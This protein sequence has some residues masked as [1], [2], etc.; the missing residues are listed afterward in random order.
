M[1][2]VS[3][4]ANSAR[5]ALQELSLE[6]QVQVACINSAENVTLSGQSDAISNLERHFSSKQ[7][8]ARKLN[9]N[10]Q[11]YHTSQMAHAEQYYRELLEGI[12][13]SFKGDAKPTDSCVSMV[14][15]LT[16]QPAVPSDISSPTYWCANLQSP[17]L[18]EHATRTLLQNH[19]CH[20]VEIGPYPALKNYILDIR[21]HIGLHETQ[22]AYF[23]SLMRDTNSTISLLNLVG[24][25]Y[26]TGEDLP[27]D[28][29]N[30]NA[31]K[32]W[33]DLPPYPWT[34]EDIPCFEP[35]ISREFRNRQYPRHELLGSR[36]VGCHADTAFWR[37]TIRLDNIPWLQDHVI[38]GTCVFPGAAYIAIAVEGLSQLC[39]LE[40]HWQS[41][42]YSTVILQEV[43]IINALRF[44]DKEQAVEMVT[45]LQPKHGLD[46]IDQNSRPKI[47]WNFTISSFANGITTIHS[48]GQIKLGT[49]TVAGCCGLP[50]ADLS[51]EDQ[52]PALWYRKLASVGL[53]FGQA[54][55]RMIRIS[56]DRMRSAH[57][58]ESV[59]SLRPNPQSVSTYLIHPTALDAL[60]QVGIIAASAGAREALTAKIPVSI[61]HLEIRRGLQQ[62][63]LNAATAWAHS[64]P[65]GFETT[66]VDIDL[67][68]PDNV[69]LL[70]MRSLR[71][72]PYQSSTTVSKS[73]GEKTPLLTIQWKPDISLLPSLECS[74]LAKYASKKGLNQLP[75]GIQH[76]I[77]IID[78]A[79]FKSPFIRILEI[80][81]EDLV[82]FSALLRSSPYDS[83]SGRFHDYA[84]VQIHPS[85]GFVGHYL[86]VDTKTL[87]LEDQQK[88]LNFEN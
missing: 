24:K 52:A 29:I 12:E 13:L 81:L 61:E 6:D 76:A 72:F 23:H 56:N 44:G 55:Q 50:H 35:S 64:R 47:W 19:E 39:Q 75:S 5:N 30:K 87:A 66:Q 7:V 42:T 67:K 73:V 63:I 21:S 78:L 77:A 53:Q 83:T 45:E 68:G 86:S 46:M 85:G 49:E 22:V 31:M 40:P 3:C 15:S 8:F 20:I 65:V 51:L 17:V 36:V 48:R 34:H 54:F 59:I 4:T 74:V 79:T 60:F 26:L 43:R 88:I 58:P 28:K 82:L 41:S 18:F 14:S 25:M 9:T 1:L 37:N 11:A 62:S 33:I 84:K 80:G 57:L 71:L 27:F 16:G 10:G 69:T 32:A 70:R 2:A 38:D